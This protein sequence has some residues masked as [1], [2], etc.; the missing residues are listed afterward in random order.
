MTFCKCKCERSQ[1]SH[2]YWGNEAV[3]LEMKSS[4]R[5]RRVWKGT[6]VL[7]I[8]YIDTSLTTWSGA[9][10][11]VSFKAWIIFLDTKSVIWGWLCNI[12]YSRRGLPAPLTTWSLGRIVLTRC[13]E[14][15][16][17]YSLPSYWW[18]SLI[19]ILQTN[20]SFLKALDVLKQG[21]YDG[22]NIKLKS[23]G[24]EIHLRHF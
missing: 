10:V 16:W 7:E 12:N 24:Y 4:S 19:C 1:S 18:L 13:I 23:D 22:V 17:T 3:E 8:Q 6:D 5:Q 20:S 15:N 11:K 2:S 21:N 9:T 14:K